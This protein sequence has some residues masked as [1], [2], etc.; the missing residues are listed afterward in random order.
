MNSSICQGS[1]LWL[2]ET[3]PDKEQESVAGLS[4]VSMITPKIKQI[5]KFIR[6]ISS[7]TNLV[8][9][10]STMQKQEALSFSSKKTLAKV[11][12][13]LNTLLYEIF[14]ERN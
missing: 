12:Y 14:E 1:L 10:L 7:A 4:M 8:A 2:R 3:I 6:E 13:A 11:R 9:L 5:H